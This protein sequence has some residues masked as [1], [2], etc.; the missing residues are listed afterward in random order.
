VNCIN[1]FNNLCNKTLTIFDEIRVP[2]YSNHYTW[3]AN[4]DRK[5]LIPKFNPYIA[6]MLSTYMNLNWLLGAKDRIEA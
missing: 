4:G 1:S 6:L 5:V 3:Q 2:Q